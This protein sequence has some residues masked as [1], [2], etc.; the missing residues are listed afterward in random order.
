MIADFLFVKFRNRDKE[1][2]RQIQN[3]SFKQV[4]ILVRNFNLFLSFALFLL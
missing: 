1:N 3:S 2:V 4:K